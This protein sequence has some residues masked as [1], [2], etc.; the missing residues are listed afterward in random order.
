[1]RIILASLMMLA[2]CAP[3]PSQQAAPTRVV[4][5]RTFAGPAPRDPAALQRV[6]LERHNAA[7]R[8]V[9]VAPLVWNDALARDAQA[10]A[11][12]MAR[13]GRFA[14][15]VQPQGLGREGENLWTGT[16]DAYRYREMVD[17]WIAEKKW[18]RNGVTPD[19]STTGN[20]EDVAH[21]TQIIW[22]GSKAVGCALASNRSDDYLV[23]RYSPPGN[24]VGQKAL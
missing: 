21:Y 16:R 12:Q 13:T 14:H 8:A 20:Y 15:A 3:S 18:F 5:P 9:G 1:M 6:M 2:A 22:R 11:E 7:R 23:C 10:Y 17:A 24:V 4:E 19:F